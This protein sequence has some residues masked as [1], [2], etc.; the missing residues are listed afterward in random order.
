MTA[1]LRIGLRV[2][3]NPAWMGGVHY[4]LT[5]A[6]T[7]RRLPT[8]ERPSVHLLFADEAAERLAREHADGVDGIHA[9]SEARRL[10][11][12]FVYPATQIFEAPFGVPWAGWIPDWQCK[13]LPELFDDVERARR[14]LH[15]RVLATRS[16]LLVVSS[17]MAWDD[18]LRVVG[19]GLA[20]VRKLSFPALVEERAFE[21]GPKELEATRRRLG[22]PARYFLVCNQFWKHKNHIVV[23]RALARLA[24][25]SVACVFTGDTTDHRWPGYFEEIRGII[26]EHDLGRSVFMLGR[27]GRDDQLRLMRTAVAV[28]QPS[29]FEGWSSVV[30]EARALRRPLILSRFPVHLEQA[31]AGSRFFD[32]DAEE[33]LSRVIREAWEAEEP[34]PL[35]PRDAIEEHARHLRSCGRRFVEAALEARRRFDPSAHDPKPALAD[36][37][38]QAWSQQTS[39]GGA[40]LAQKVL[41]GLRV[42]LRAHPEEAAGFLDVVRHSAPASAARAA[43]AALR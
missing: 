38:T 1:P 11:L 15:Y 4:V 42:M 19:A 25:P 24:D 28:I 22:L 10:G 13:H 30:E 43:Q 33:E 23:F 6:R 21:A 31:P 32:P 34:I 7:L 12:D 35:A 18:T 36:L 17:Q 29:R 16:P 8:A 20:P 40:A 5:W 2:F 3:A 26:R 41:A 14:D 39:P 37:L 9:F 27:I